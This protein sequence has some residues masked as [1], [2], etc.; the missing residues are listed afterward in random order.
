MSFSE[1]LVNDFQ[2]LCEEKH[3]KKYTY[4]EAEEALKSLADFYLIFYE[5]HI[6]E[7]KRKEKLKEFPKGYSLMDGGVY[8]CG[9]CGNR[10]QD[11]QLWYDKWGNKCLS[12]QEAINKK[13]ISGFV[14]RNRDIWYSMFDFEHY[15]KLKSATVRSLVKSGVLK[16]RITGGRCYVF[17]IKENK[18]T[19]PPKSLLKSRS[20][21]ISEDTF[22]MEQWYQFQN[23]NEVLKNYKILPHISL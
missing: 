15:F 14:C 8:N 10:I 16:A 17:L 5:S 1:K 23:P 12:C 13:I 11:E 9:V 7:L 18:D 4:E 6:E 22:R 3:G 19:L 21:R 2:R 20:L